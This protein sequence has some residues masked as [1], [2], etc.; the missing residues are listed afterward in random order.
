[1][2]KIK[3]EGVGY[4]LGLRKCLKK[5]LVC[6]SNS[7]IDDLRDSGG[8]IIVGIEVVEMVTGALQ[9]AGQLQTTGLEW[10]E[11]AGAEATGS[12]ALGGD[13]A[14]KYIKRMED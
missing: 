7:L 9:K 2:Q 13:L 8:G 14:F 11:A 6:P 12:M 4:S 1:M 10:L 3:I 5:G